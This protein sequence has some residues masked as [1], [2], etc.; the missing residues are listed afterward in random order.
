MAWQ[1]SAKSSTKIVLLVI[2][3]SHS[4][5]RGRYRNKFIPLTASSSDPST[6]I[7]KNSKDFCSMPNSSRIESSLRTC[8]SLL[9]VG[10]MTLLLGCSNSLKVDIPEF[11]DTV[12]G[13]M[14]SFEPAAQQIVVSRS[15][16]LK[17]LANSTTGSIL[18]PDHP[19]S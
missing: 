7:F 2:V 12:N 9:M 10:G 1:I 15:L 16:H 3:A 13:S 19:L 14:S 4:I 18:M 17:V 6:S 11:S 5:T 8:T